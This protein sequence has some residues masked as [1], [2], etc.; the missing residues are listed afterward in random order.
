MDDKKVTVEEIKALLAGDFE[1]FAERMAYWSKGRGTV[2]PA[3]ALLGITRGT[4]FR[5]AF[6]SDAARSRWTVPSPT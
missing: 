4:T 5:S 3:D 2:Y 6:A 1:Q